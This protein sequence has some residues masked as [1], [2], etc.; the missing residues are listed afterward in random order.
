MVNINARRDERLLL[1]VVLVS[2][3]Q[4]IIKA[5]ISYAV[6]HIIQRKDMYRNPGLVTF[7]FD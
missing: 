3:L 4:A 5:L 2:R 1:S 6:P 7:P